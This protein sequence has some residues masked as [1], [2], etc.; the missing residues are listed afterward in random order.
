MGYQYRYCLFCLVGDYVLTIIRYF[1][2][3]SGGTLKAMQQHVL[4]I[5]GSLAQMI[6]AR[7]LLLVSCPK[8]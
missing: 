2:Y 3:I 7:I 8:V 4:V 1:Y 5:L 6:D